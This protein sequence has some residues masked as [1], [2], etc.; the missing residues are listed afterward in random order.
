MF[1]K[2]EKSVLKENHVLCFAYNLSRFSDDFDPCFENG[3]RCSIM[4]GYVYVSEGLFW[5][6]SLLLN[7]F[8]KVFLKNLFVKI[9]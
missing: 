7:D 8:S 9:V 6:I 3:Y 1:L 4:L 5:K 2:E